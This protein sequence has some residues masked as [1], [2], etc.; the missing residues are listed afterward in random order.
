MKIA[1]RS[2][3]EPHCGEFVARVAKPQPHRADENP[4]FFFHE[5]IR[6][7]FGGAAVEANEMSRAGPALSSSSRSRTEAPCKDAASRYCRAIERKLPGA[8]I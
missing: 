6:Y 3:M 4:I 5:Q 1:R 8:G 2:N 7:Q